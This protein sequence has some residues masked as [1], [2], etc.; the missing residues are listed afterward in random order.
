M[1]FMEGEGWLY[2]ALTMVLKA[3][4][5]SAFKIEIPGLCC[6]WPPRLLHTVLLHAL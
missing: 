6:F 5:E 3:L 1:D 4:A 2:S